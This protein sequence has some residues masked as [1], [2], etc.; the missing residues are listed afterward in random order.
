M[1]NARANGQVA[2][3]ASSLQVAIGIVMIVSARFAWLYS[4]AATDTP[5]PALALF[6]FELPLVFCVLPFITSEI[7]KRSVR[8][9]GMVFGTAL[10]FC[11]LALPLWFDAQ[12]TAWGRGGYP[13]TLAGFLPVCFILAVWILAFSWRYGKVDRREFI[14]SAKRGILCFLFVSL[15]VLLASFWGR[16]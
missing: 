9:A 10:S 5:P 16:V 12:L 11:P 3:P 15:L 13:G 1:V 6:L 7:S 14:A 4:H 8:S 2:D